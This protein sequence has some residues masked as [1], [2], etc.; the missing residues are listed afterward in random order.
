LSHISTVINHISSIGIVLAGK[1]AAQ[2]VTERAL[3]LD[4]SVPAKAI[5]PEIVEAA[6]LYKA[7]DPVGI[8]GDNAFSFGGGMTLSNFK[9]GDIVDDDIPR[10][11]VFEKQKP[12][13]LMRTINDNIKIVFGNKVSK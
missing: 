4:P 11:A 10:P 2:V 5:Q 1:L 9:S 13:D 12:F 8:S 7:R 3:S 6:A